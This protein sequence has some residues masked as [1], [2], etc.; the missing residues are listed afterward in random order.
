MS[1]E[2]LRTGSDAEIL[3]DL[4][5]KINGQEKAQARTDSELL[6]I[7]ASLSDLSA[8]LKE[9]SGKLNAGT[10]W[11]AFWAAAGV[12]FSLIVGLGTLVTLPIHDRLTRLEAFEVRAI[13]DG[14]TIAMLQERSEWT[15]LA[16]VGR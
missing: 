2:E 4:Y 8:A 6:G 13:E 11:N 15:R 16:T 3:R 1:D 9:I 10:D 12:M 7:K 5:L 14:K